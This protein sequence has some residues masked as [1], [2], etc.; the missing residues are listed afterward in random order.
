MVRRPWPTGVNGR[1]A[2]RERDARDASSTCSMP[3]TSGQTIASSVDHHRLM[4]VADVVG[5]ERPLRRRPRLDHE[6][7]LRP[8]DDGHDQR[9]PRRAR[10]SRRRAARCR[11]AAP[12]RTR[13]RRPT[14]A[15]RAPSADPPSRAS[16]CRARTRAPRPAASPRDTTSRDDGQRLECSRARSRH[17]TR[18]TLSRRASVRATFWTCSQNRKYRCA[19]GSTSA[20]SHVS[21]SP[22]ARTS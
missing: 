17:E 16:P 7:R 9:A 8:L 5:E 15:G 20:G 6:H 21:S 12:C 14:A 1:V 3:G 10:S 18:R 22:S 19:S 11:A 13:R 2:A 4:A